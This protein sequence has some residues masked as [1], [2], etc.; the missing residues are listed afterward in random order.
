MLVLSKYI[1]ATNIVT[2]NNTGMNI[3]VENIHILIFILSLLYIYK[4]AGCHI[5]IY[6]WLSYL[7]MT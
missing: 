4:D 3:C 6:V 1:T 2:V 7:V 5:I